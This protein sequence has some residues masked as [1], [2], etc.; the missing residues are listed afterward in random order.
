MIRR[1]GFVTGSA[2]ALIASACGRQVTP[3]RVGVGPGGLQPGFMSVKFNVQ[4]AF[5]FSADSYAIVFNTSG[6]GVTPLPVAQTTNWAGYSIAIV[7]GGAAGTIAPYA[8]YYYRPSNTTQAPVLYPI[9]ATPQQVILQSNSN[10]Q[11]TQFTVIFDTII[12]SFNVTTTPSPSP[13]TSAS[14][15]PTPTAS[16]SASPFPSP[17]GS[18]V[19][20]SNLWNF[21]FF[22]VQGTVSQYESQGSLQII[23][24]LGAG[25]PN[26]T[27]YISQQLNL[28]TSFDTG[29]FY[30]QAGTH[31]SIP[32]AIA[33]GDIAN[34][35]AT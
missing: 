16:A 13:T 14:A 35:P 28:A 12:A 27:T 18:G 3:N 19:G 33:G 11:G 9:G 34:N 23:D 5:N 26:D 24:S 8:Y 22:V 29:A 4:S 20:V 10:G 15:S 7:V 2:A 1:A 6:S 25:G 30:V 21:N 32:D 31:P 17:T